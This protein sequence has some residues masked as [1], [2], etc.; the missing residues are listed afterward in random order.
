MQWNEYYEQNQME[1]EENRISEEEFEL[2]KDRLPIM[3]TV[4]NKEIDRKRNEL[5]ANLKFYQEWIGYWKKLCWGKMYIKLF[6][7]K[8]C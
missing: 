8:V 1:S 5:L 4:I 3:E 2:D 6:R 7:I